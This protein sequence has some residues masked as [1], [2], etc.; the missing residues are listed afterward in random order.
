MPPEDIGS[1]SLADATT[2]G[3]RFSRLACD[4]C[5][6]RKARCDKILPA[7]TTCARADAEC[8]YNS[9][10]GLA[11]RDELV[12]S[13]ERRLRQMDAKNRALSKELQQARAKQVSTDHTARVVASGYGGSSTSPGPVEQDKSREVDN[14][15]EVAKQVFSLSLN[16]GSQSQYLGSAS[17]AILANLL[18]VHG[19]IVTADSDNDLV[20]RRF[21]PGAGNNADCP[22]GETGHQP[23]ER[24]A[25]DLMAAY[26]S[27]DHICYPYLDPHDLITSLTDLYA[28]NTYLE[29][30]PVETFTLDMVFAIATAQVHKYSW[31]VMPDAETYYERAISRFGTALEAGGLVALQSI[32]LLCQYRMLSIS[33]STSA[34]LWHLLGMAARLGLEMGL[35]RE[36]VYV[37]PPDLSPAALGRA[38]RKN[39]V[40]RRCFWCLFGMDRIVSNTLGRPMAINLD[41]I[42]TAYPSAEHEQHPLFSSTP[43]ADEVFE[44]SQEFRNTSVFVHITRH[45]VLTGKILS[46]LHNVPKS[47]MPDQTTCA[48]IRQQLSA[49]LD[50]WKRGVSSLP[51]TDTKSGRQYEL[52]TF[53]SLEWYRLLYHNCILMLY[54]PIYTTDDASPTAEVLERLY[55]SSRQSIHAYSLLHRDRRINYTWITLHA[56]FIVGL[57][58]VY[59]VRTHFQNRRRHIKHPLERQPRPAEGQLSADPAISQIV[60]DTRACSTVLVALSERWNTAREC[61]NVFGRLC[62]AVIVDASDFHVNSSQSKGERGPAS[63]QAQAEPDELPLFDTLPQD[64]FSI[65]AATDLD[66]N[67]QGCFEDLQRVLGGHYDD[68][69]N[70]L[71]WPQFDMDLGFDS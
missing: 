19:R 15:N 18:G 24:L 33:Y 22:G 44:A 30:H 12:E 1:T 43:T 39:E 61:H 47:R 8:C 25:R 69:M 64:D 34:S 57:S 45:R 54:R 56:V 58:Y 40:K 28:D 53:K 27:H 9:R 63:P 59:A 23:S 14:G 66:Q 38:R 13:L 26:L 60:S 48:V 10:Q 17:G 70:A 29:R 65:F 51:L 35:H 67:Y 37:I 49:E 16:A 55:H 42:D 2:V 71:L 11:R 32:M 46:S 5:Y 31:H 68:N 50:E 36:A 7:C 4:R 41:D 6:R 21:D 20:F 52:S 62:D 3:D